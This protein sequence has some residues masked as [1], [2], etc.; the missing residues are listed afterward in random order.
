[1]PPNPSMVKD[2]LKGI[3]PDLPTGV[4]SFPFIIPFLIL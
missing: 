2:R 1:M 3:K 4:N